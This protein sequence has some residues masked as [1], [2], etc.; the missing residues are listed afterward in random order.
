M[1][2]KIQVLMTKEQKRF[3]SKVEGWLGLARSAGIQIYAIA[4]EVAKGYERDRLEL[5]ALKSGGTYRYASDL[6]SLGEATANLGRE[7]NEQVVLTFVDKSATPVL[8]FL[9]VSRSLTKR[10]MDLKKRRPS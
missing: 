3:A 2:N 5:L 10:G 9:M 8:R 4:N 6:N 1:T 7:L